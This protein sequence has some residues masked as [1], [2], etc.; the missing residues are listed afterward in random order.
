MSLTQGHPEH[1]NLTTESALWGKRTL[2]VTG[3]QTAANPAASEAPPLVL[4]THRLPGP[5][6]GLR[7]QNPRAGSALQPG[8]ATMGPALG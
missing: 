7:K 6:P 3:S 1:M 5:H 8:E 2:N 4:R